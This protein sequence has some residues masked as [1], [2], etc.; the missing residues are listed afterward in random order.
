MNH[1]I[2]SGVY[3]V[4][5][6]SKGIGRAIASL[7]AAKGAQLILLARDKKALENTARELREKY[8]TKSVSVFSCD[9]G[10]KTQILHTAKEIRKKYKALSGMIHVAG[11]ARPGYFHEL[12]LDDFEKSMRIDYLGA[13]YLTHALHSLVNDDGLI[14]FTSS[15]AG[16]MG[17]FGYTAY[18][19]PKFALVGF[20]ETLRQE[21]L[22]RKIQIS[23]LCPPDTETPGYTEENKTKP[24]ETQALSKNAKLMPPEKVAQKFIQ[25]IAKKKFIVTCNFESAMLYRLHGLWPSLIFRIMKS[26]IQKAQKK[27]PKN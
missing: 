5:G 22:Q 14:A 16:Y 12:D 23:V 1:P 18:A 2:P 8:N 20:A 26:M 15:V 7:L 6:A 11:Y 3:L 10:D 4:T 9:L 17:V 21:M 25:G 19:G 27:L 13:V 24:F